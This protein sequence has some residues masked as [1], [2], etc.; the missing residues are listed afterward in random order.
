MGQLKDEL[1]VMAAYFV[2]VYNGLVIK[3]ACRWISA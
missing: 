3:N 1:W 2:V